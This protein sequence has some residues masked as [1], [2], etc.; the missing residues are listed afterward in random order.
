M[1]NIRKVY[2]FS[3]F[4][5][6]SF[7][8]GNGQNS[9]YNLN[10]T[11]LINIK[12][13]DNNNWG[14]TKKRVVNGTTQYTLLNSSP[15]IIAAE[16]FID[17]DPGIGNGTSFNG[18]N[19]DSIN[20][21]TK[22]AIPKSIIGGFH[23]LY[24]RVKDSLNNWSI[25][26]K[27]SFYIDTT[28]KISSVI[29]KIVAAEY[30][31]GVDSGIGKGTSISVAK[32]DSILQNVGIVLPKLSIGTS[33]INVRYKDSLGRWGI[34]ES[35]GINVVCKPN[36]GNDTSIS[37]CNL[38]SVNITGL[39]NYKNY[40]SYT[41][42]TSRPDSITQPGKYLLIAT[43]IY[44]CR[45]TAVVSV[46]TINPSIQASGLSNCNSVVFNGTI[47]YNSTTITDTIRTIGGCD[48]VYKI[49]YISIKKIIPVKGTNTISGCNSV[50]YNYRYYFSSTVLQDTLKSLQG[51]DSVYQTVNIIIY[52]ISPSSNIV[53]LSGCDR[54][55]YHSHI[56]SAST[57]IE[58]TI[59]SLSG[60]DSIYQIAYITITHNFN[61]KFDTVNVSGCDSI[62]YNSVMYKNS[63][64]Y[65]DTF[66]TT[67]GCDSDYHITNI[68]VNNMNVSGGL[69]YPDNKLIPNTTVG[70]SGINNQ[71]EMFSDDYSF[72]CLSHS[73]N[74]TIKV[75][76]NFEG[77]K[78]NGVTALD[79]ALVQSHILQKNLFNSPYKIIAADVN[80]D[81]TVSVLDIVY[82][83]RL[84]LGIDTSFTKTSTGAK[85]LWVF[86]D[87]SYKYPDTTKPF[88]IKD[89]II[90]TGTN[91]N[92]T[93][94]TFIGCKLGDVNWDWNPAVSKPQ[95]NT[96]NVVELYY[97]SDIIQLLDKVIIPIKVKNFKEMLGMQFT[98]SFNATV[99]QWQ[100][101][102]NNP[103][104]IETG[105]NHANDGSVSFLWVDTKNVIKTLED[106]SVLVEL[107]FNKVGNCINQQLDLNSS[108]TTIA[109]YDKDDN[110]HNIVMN[111]SLIT[112]ADFVSESWKVVPN[113]TVS[114]MIRIQMHLKESKS[115]LFKLIDVTGKVLFVHRN[116]GVK[117]D[118]TLILKSASQIPNG[119]YF[120]QALGVEGDKVKKIIVQN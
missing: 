78:T 82:I 29:P 44:G 13:E 63:F 10:T 52:K 98:I 7:L 11:N 103:L 97:S 64:S 75:T 74:N 76:K 5:I 67:T 4:M 79:I 20:I 39:Y 114:G 60:C 26:E 25:A 51:C 28:V 48:S 92:N 83:K 3:F 109:A 30:F 93:H 49:T 106:G 36:L 37:L 40:A 100:G 22:I 38:K 56:Y 41:W 89:S 91:L 84:I 16:Y 70:I 108:V 101:I 118:N 35:R 58:D 85:R 33:T 6:I 117:G 53:F 81:G 94:Q 18:L 90:C 50:W 66:Y 72:G 54:V 73:V 102:G 62:F 14:F 113:P 23:Q 15:V 19:S 88:P 107:V 9:N 12:S 8:K 80:G 47:Y 86:V 59:R 31:F 77:T 116:E 27:R 2:I 42:S 99:L 111:P 46:Q 55:Y 21:T 87:S 32:A 34:A 65:I 61:P 112:I 110:F 115:I 120:I 69:L 17:K 24:F 43:S 1:K 57:E 71:T 105:T 95:F 96:N 45:D 68:I 104:G 119:I